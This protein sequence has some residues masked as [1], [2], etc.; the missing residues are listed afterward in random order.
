ML[1]GHIVFS[2]IAHSHPIATRC[3]LPGKH[4][5]W[6]EQNAAWLE[7]ADELWVGMIEGWDQSVGIKWEVEKARLLGKRIAYCPG[8]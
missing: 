8:V 4:D 2:P 6:Q 5:F 1:Q 7:W 3:S